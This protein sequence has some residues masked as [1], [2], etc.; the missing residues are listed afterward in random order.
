MAP[1]LICQRA[2]V[3]PVVRRAAVRATA[4]E[5]PLRILDRREAFFVID[6]IFRS[7]TDP[8]ERVFGLLDGYRR[9]LHD[10]ACVRGCPIG[11]LAVEVGDES[12][13]V[14]KRIAANFLAW[15]G[16]VERCFEEVTD[17][18]VPEADSAALASYALA[19]MEGAV[20]QAR[21]FRSL[22]PFDEAID[23]LRDHVERL[24]LPAEPHG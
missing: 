9:Q 2:A 10:S 8:I 6:P 22:A 16:A 7:H 15:R 14:R 24:R 21:T 1:T 17:R 18:L 3:P 11:N 19:V 23:M 12:E 4:L 20:M 13:E 5:F